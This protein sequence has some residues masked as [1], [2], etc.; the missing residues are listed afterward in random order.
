MK[1]YKYILMFLTLVL[2]SACRE[3]NFLP[4]PVGKK[5]V[6][7]KQLITEKE[8]EPLARIYYMHGNFINSKQFPPIVNAEEVLDNLNNW[9]LIDIRKSDAY[10]AGHING[11]YNVPKDKV[12]DF[13][14]NKQKAS[15]YPKVV[16]IC[17]TGQMASYVTGITRFS[18]FD[19]TYVMLF[20]MAGWNEQ[21]SAPLKAGYGTRYQD[22]IVKTSNKTETISNNHEAKAGAHK[23]IDLSKL[24]K[25]PQKAPSE[26]MKVQ[27]QK[28]LLQGRKEFLLKANEF[29]HDY[30]ANPNKYLPLFY[31]SKDKYYV[32]HIK[33]A[34][35]Y[36]SRKDLS[37]DAKLT[38]LPTDKN[39]VV[40]C[41]T[42]HT[43]GNATAYLN[44]LGY[45][46]ENL[47]FGSSSF[48]FDL[49]KKEGWNTDI[50]N[51]INNFPVVEGSK[52]TSA[53]IVASAPKKVGGT[54]KPIV[55]RKKKEVSGGCG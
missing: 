13:I 55:K 18:G 23:N 4:E 44:M 38:D 39:I 11:A 26:L 36:Q 2:L 53:K 47:M 40:Y 30:K 50:S 43:G 19:N 41:K 42:G 34:V 29:F 15:A 3:T 27:A 45:K 22:M 52:R 12:L 24:P 35:F 51:L 48:M 33:G 54:T 14:K 7:F 32:A 16:F 31:L 1:N 9:L 49:W 8:Q 6:D 10:E 25:L 17:Y 46:A 5:D 28:L 21:F 37:L 20:G